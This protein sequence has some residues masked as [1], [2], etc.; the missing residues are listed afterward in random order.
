MNITPAHT[1]IRSDMF[2]HAPPATTTQILHLTNSNTCALTR[3]WPSKTL[4][5]KSWQRTQYTPLQNLTDSPPC[6]RLLT[7]QNDTTSTYKIRSLALRQHIHLPIAT[8]PIS[9]RFHFPPA[10]LARLPSTGH[11]LIYTDGSF[12]QPLSPPGL[13]IPTP[14]TS[15]LSLII[16]TEALTPDSTTTYL[17]LT[18]TGPTS[19]SNSYQAELLAASAAASLSTTTRSV[20]II[21]D[22]KSV[23]TQIHRLR[24]PNSHMPRT[25][26]TH[27]L[28]LIL[29]TSATLT[30]VKAHSDL[31][32]STPTTYQWGNQIADAFARNI[33]P[34]KWAP[35]PSSTYHTT[36]ADFLPSYQCHTTFNSDHATVLPSSHALSKHLSQLKINNY[37]TNRHTT[38]YQHLANWSEYSWTN[39]GLSIKKLLKGEGAYNS[40]TISNIKAIRYFFKTLYDKFRN[41]AYIH[42]IQHPRAPTPETTQVEPPTCPLCFNSNDSITHLFCHCTHPTIQDLRASCIQAINSHFTKHPQSSLPFKP[43]VDA[44]SLND[45]RAWACLLPIDTSPL[46]D[47]TTTATHILPFTISTVYNMWKAY[48]TITHI[49]QTTSTHTTSHAI[50]SKTAKI[51]RVKGPRP[52]TQIHTCPIIFHPPTR[53]HDIRTYLSVTTQQTAAATT[54]TTPTRLSS[55]NHTPNTIPL[56]NTFSQLTVDELEQPNNIHYNYPPPPSTPINTANSLS[57]YESASP[58]AAIRHLTN[59]LHFNWERV[60]GDGDCLLHSVKASLAHLPTLHNPLLLTSTYLRNRIHQFLISSRGRDICDRH[61]LTRDLIDS[62]RPTTTSRGS[63]LELFAIEALQEILNINITTYFLVRQANQYTVT[64]EQLSHQ[65]GRPNVTILHHNNNHFSGLSPFHPP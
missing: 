53:S 26:I 3:K 25:D 65:P 58:S 35:S 16:T 8:R 44:L 57:P 15:S 33:T 22:C 41:H 14:A 23:V 43:F 37:I 21:T 61:F 60:A 36:L 13:Q 2:L 29:S 31:K 48:N 27:Y 51:I 6:T 50:L 56:H 46:K 52:Q 59:T 55:I 12:T 20:H 54:W 62:I 1:T 10:L 40:L 42:K 39:T 11:L 17:A 45:S 49:P 47:Y 64:V 7:Y 19:L 34:P 9:P 18:V 30:H 4:S 5:I 24:N 38:Y 32:S 28:R 63:W